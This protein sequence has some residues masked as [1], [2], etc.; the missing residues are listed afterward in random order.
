MYKCFN[1]VGESFASVYHKFL[2]SHACSKDRM[3]AWGEF[4]TLIRWVGRI[5]VSLL[6][7]TNMNLKR[8]HIRKSRDFY[9]S[10][11]ECSAYSFALRIVGSTNVALIESENIPPCALLHSAYGLCTYMARV[12]LFAHYWRNGH[13]I[14]FFIRIFILSLKP[15]SWTC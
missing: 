2:L 6:Q 9:R 1:G 7:K 15:D 4:L 10:F 13:F 12:N 3:H 14:C 5:L 11:W 8:K